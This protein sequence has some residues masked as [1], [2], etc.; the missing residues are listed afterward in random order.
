MTRRAWGNRYE[1]E[2]RRVK[3]EMGKGAEIKGAEINA[4]ARARAAVWFWLRSP[5]RGRTYA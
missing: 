4:T 5:W 1:T 2:W 3:K